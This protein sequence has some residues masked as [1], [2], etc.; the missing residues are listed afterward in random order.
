MIL[1]F[2]SILPEKYEKKFSLLIVKKAVT[3]IECADFLRSENISDGMKPCCELAFA[4][5]TSTPLKK[6]KA[7]VLF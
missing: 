6:H 2:L 7:Y 3:E 4:R 1:K 5:I